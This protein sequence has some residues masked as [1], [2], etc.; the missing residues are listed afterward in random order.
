MVSAGACLTLSQLVFHALATV[1]ELQAFV[2]ISLLP[3]G[4]PQVEARD[5]LQESVDVLRPRPKAELLYAQ[6]GFSDSNPYAINV[7]ASH[8]N[9]SYV[10]IEEFESMLSQI[11]CVDA[12]VDLPTSV[13]LRFKDDDLFMHARDLWI[14]HDSLLFVTHHD[15]CN[16]VHKRGVYR[17]SSIK[18]EERSLD[19]IISS[20]YE[21]LG[22][23]SH[24]SSVI[25]VSGGLADAHLA[26]RLRRRTIHPRDSKN[27]ESQT[28]ALTLN[29]HH[30]FQPREQIMNAGMEGVIQAAF[31][32]TINTDISGVLKEIGDDFKELGEDAKV[33]FSQYAGSD[34]QS[35]ANGFMNVFN[36]IGREIG[37]FFH[38][39]ASALGLARRDKSSSADDFLKGM[40][41]EMSFSINDTTPVAAKFNIEFFSN[42]LVGLPGLLTFNLGPS[43]G[44]GATPAPFKL[45]GWTFEIVAEPI[46]ITFQAQMRPGTN[47]VK[48][49]VALQATIVL[50]R[51]KVCFSE[52]YNVDSKCGPKG[53]IPE[54]L[55]MT[56]TMNIG[57]ELNLEA[58]VF[59]FVLMDTLLARDLTALGVYHNWTLAKDCIDKR[60]FKPGT[61]LDAKPKSVVDGKEVTP[62]RARAVERGHNVTISREGPVA[63]RGWRGSILRRRRRNSKH[64]AHLIPPLRKPKYPPSLMERLVYKDR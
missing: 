17:S 44:P 28:S 43:V 35:S 60:G 2:P 37:K 61:P 12:T 36:A 52:A 26:R 15:S 58:G 22:D 41:Q 19:V 54:A 23:S 53:P 1:I 4:G 11:R 18:F 20:S 30:S 29:L 34:I 47:A 51:M 64:N 16:E 38:S 39:I 13:V 8:K 33:F 45:G 57:L 55:S 62:V 7:T 27:I 25:H 56:T 63:S 3:V 40:V 5:P 59:G 10:I 14:R 9:S 32:I 42:S 21:E 48:T 49:H 46:A 50:P 6:H 24:A 31:N